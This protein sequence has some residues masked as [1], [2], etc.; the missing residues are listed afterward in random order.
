MS[1]SLPIRLLDVLPER[2]KARRPRGLARAALAPP[3]PLASVFRSG[4]PERVT[5]RISIPAN[6]ILK[7]GG[8]S[9]ATPDRIRE[10]VR[11]VLEADADTRAVVVVSAFQ[12]VTTQILES[13]RFAAL[14][15]NAYQ[16]VFDEVAARHRATLDDLFVGGEREQIRAAVDGLLEELRQALQAIYRVG[17]ASSASLDLAAS[18]G[19]RLSASI[20]AAY[21]DPMRIARYVDAREFVITDD[22]F[23]HANVL[24]AR[25]NRATRRY[26]SALLSDRGNPIPVVTGFIGSTIDG[27][28][29]TV[30]RNGSDYTATLIGAALRASA[31]EIWSDVDGVLSADPKTVSSA[32]V[33]PQITYDQAMEMSHFGAKVLHPAS[34]APAV[35]RSIPIL[36]KNTLNP[37]APGTLI[38]ARVTNGH[39]LATGVSSM[40]DLT[41]FTLRP[42]NGARIPATAERLRRAVTSRA[43]PVMLSSEEGSE[44]GVSVAVHTSAARIAAE[45]V[46]QEFRSE[47]EQGLTVL[48][49][50]PNQAIVA[51]VG[52]G[53]RAKADVAW[54][55]FASLGRYNIDVGAI[56]QGIS[57]RTIACI[58]DASEQARALNVIHRGFFEARK[59]LALAIIGV[60]RV[61]SALL[62]QLLE[63]DAYLQEQGF[64]VSVVALADSKRFLVSPDGIELANWRAS[65]DASDQPMNL[66]ALTS[67][68]A[69]LRLTNAAV[70]DCTADA[71]VVDTY[72]DF[73]NAGLHIITPNKRAN[74][75]PW[76]RYSALMDL[77]A[78]RRKHF[79][80]EANVGAGLPVI[81]TLRDLVASGDQIVRV[82]GIV[83]GTL[84]YLFN[85]FD[86]S[87]PFSALVRDAQQKGMTEPDPREDLSGQDV[88]RK[89]LILA[90]QAGT[91][92]EM[93]DVQVETLVP[94]WRTGHCRLISSTRS[95]ST[96]T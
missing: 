51:M 8:S 76:R 31:I 21:L 66:N 6:R 69:D 20:L 38:K 44:H 33:L 81:S 95:R 63:R 84:S 32:F 39:R 47:L 92:L 19:E 54:N 4:Q 91:Q 52:E 53:V 49:E 88:A 85:T 72:L 71:G 41:L 12:G 62:A 50:K 10:V 80:F 43:V 14:R 45:A 60:G 25:T 57:N 89:L 18:H 22:Q 79:F 13:A 34:V 40:A 77:L 36:I 94:A 15:D 61:G 42:M 2:A 59:P 87:V 56:A 16:N 82:E 27:Q 7:F 73:V 70:I 67:R 1:T 68:L 65:L 86:G 78:T 90:R 30:G 96:I 11:I 83:S 37:T 9:V 48:D 55:A 17:H 46:R 3:V 5:R 24:L 74:V 64:H 29:T 26:F 23:T 28:T 58:V 75:L 35:S 93:E